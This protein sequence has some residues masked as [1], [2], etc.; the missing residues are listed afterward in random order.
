MLEVPRQ[1]KLPQ[2]AT[3]LKTRLLAKLVT[4]GVREVVVRLEGSVQSGDQVEQSLATDCVTERPVLV[5]G[6]T[7]AANTHTFRQKKV[8]VGIFQSIFW[9]ISDGCGGWK[10]Y[11]QLRKCLERIIA[12]LV[13]Q[14]HTLDTKCRRRIK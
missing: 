9:N 14:S 2:L 5:P 12:N 3:D 7:S 8:E 11:F 4:L 6:H 10:C 13:K 1:H